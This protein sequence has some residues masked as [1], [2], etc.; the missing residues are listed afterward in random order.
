MDKLISRI[1]KKIRE[2]YARLKA[3]TKK[4]L[5]PLYLFPIKILTYSIFYLLQFTFRLILSLI[6]IFFE[7]IAFPFRSLKNLIKSIFVMGLV[8]CTRIF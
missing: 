8:G 2:F 1:D 6:K 4:L 5:F 3:Y 7:T